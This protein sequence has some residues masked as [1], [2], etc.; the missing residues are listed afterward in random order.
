V[1]VVYVNHPNHKALVHRS[2]CGHY[3]DRKADHLPTGFWSRLFT[4][5]ASV[6]DFALMTRKRRVDDARCCL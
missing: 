1:F 4:E 2:D 3:L 5:Q 6:R